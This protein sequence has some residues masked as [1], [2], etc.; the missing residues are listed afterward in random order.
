MGVVDTPTNANFIDYVTEL[1]LLTLKLKRRRWESTVHCI[2]LYW[3]SWTPFVDREGPWWA[4]YRTSVLW[5]GI[6]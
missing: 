4:L 1:C 6:I 5:V 3:T 2:L